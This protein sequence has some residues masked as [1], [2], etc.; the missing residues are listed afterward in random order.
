MTEKAFQILI[1]EVIF[2][3]LLF[4]VS[5][6]SICMCLLKVCALNHPRCG[7]ESIDQLRAHTSGFY[8]CFLP[9]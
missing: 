4:S 6:V 8:A 7:V 3:L 9:F 1:S 2:S 5:L